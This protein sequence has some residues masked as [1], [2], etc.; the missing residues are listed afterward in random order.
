MLSLDGFADLVLVPFAGSNPRR[1]ANSATDLM[2]T[3]GG[4]E[5]WCEFHLTGAAVA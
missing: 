5:T 3:P 1:S 2:V 4:R